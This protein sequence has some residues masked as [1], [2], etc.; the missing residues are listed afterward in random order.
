M[1]RP[2]NPLPAPQFM[3]LP[4]QI[5]GNINGNITSSALLLE[6]KSVTRVEHIVTCWDLNR[7]FKSTTVGLRPHCL[8]QQPWATGYGSPNLGGGEV[9]IPKEDV[10]IP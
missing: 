7:D 3:Y 8:R 6:T 10:S 1:I 5:P 2:Y 9:F 4:N